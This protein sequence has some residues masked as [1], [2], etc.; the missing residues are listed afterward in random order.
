MTLALSVS[1][2]ARNAL[3]RPKD[4]FSNLTFNGMVIF[5][6]GQGIESG[7]LLFLRP[8]ENA[9]EQVSK[10]ASLHRPMI[11]SNGLRII[12]T[13]RDFCVVK[14]ILCDTCF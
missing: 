2:K 9:I 1:P 13:R 7:F 10:L 4:M 14:Q 6:G 5:N 8:A 11:S 3:A 12:L